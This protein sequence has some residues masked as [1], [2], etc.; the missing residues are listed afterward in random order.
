M[1]QFHVS[2]VIVQDEPARR[3]IRNAAAHGGIGM[4]EAL[5]A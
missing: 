1:C 2:R 4:R 3:E 5:Q